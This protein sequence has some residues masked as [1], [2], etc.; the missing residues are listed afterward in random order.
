MSLYTTI[1]DVTKVCTH[2]EAIGSL[3]QII[4][5]RFSTR[6]LKA[7]PAPRRICIDI[8]TASWDP[9]AI[10][11]QSTLALSISMTVK[12]VVGTGIPNNPKSSFLYVCMDF[13]QPGDTDMSFAELWWRE[14]GS[15]LSREKGAAR[16]DRQRHR[17]GSRLCFHASARTQTRTHMHLVVSAYLYFLSPSSPLE[18]S[19]CES[20]SARSCWGVTSRSHCSKSSISGAMRLRAASMSK[21][22]SC[23]CRRAFAGDWSCAQMLGSS[24][25]RVERRPRAEDGVHTGGRSSCVTRSRLVPG[26]GKRGAMAQR[27]LPPSLHS[28]LKTLFRVQ[29]PVGVEA[30]VLRVV[31]CGLTS[32]RLKRQARGGWRSGCISRRQQAPTTRGA[33]HDTSTSPA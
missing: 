3:S 11:N 17:K 13:Q 9:R 16:S 27:R 2:C 5:T 12:T 28:S 19:I 22:A 24:R 1:L 7:L 26:N 18:T 30:K 25:P 21:N 31:A 6:T 33:H 4:L 15:C 14:S 10:L 32:W 8:T 29:L 23:L 20:G